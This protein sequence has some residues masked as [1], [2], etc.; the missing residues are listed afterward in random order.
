MTPRRRQLDNAFGH[1]HAKPKDAPMQGSF[2]LSK[3]D[4]PDDDVAPTQAYRRQ[5]WLWLAAITC[6]A[7]IASIITSQE[8]E[9]SGPVE[10][11][12]LP[13]LEK[14]VELVHASTEIAKATIR[15]SNLDHEREITTGLALHQLGLIIDDIENYQEMYAS[16]ISFELLPMARILNNLWEP[17]YNYSA[18]AGCANMT[19]TLSLEAYHAMSFL[20]SRAVYVYVDVRLKFVSRMDLYLSGMCSTL[21]RL[22]SK[23][24]M[25][26]TGDNPSE[27]DIQIANETA[28]NVLKNFSI[29]INMAIRGLDEICEDWGTVVDGMREVTKFLRTV[30][31][32]Y[33]NC[34][35]PATQKLQHGI[36]ELR[37]PASR[38]FLSY[39]RMHWLFEASTR[40][41]DEAMNLL[42]VGLLPS[43]RRLERAF[44]VEDE[45]YSQLCNNTTGLLA[46]WTRL[47]DLVNQFLQP[48]SK[49]AKGKPWMDRELGVHWWVTA[50]EEVHDVLEPLQMQLQ[51]AFELT[52][53]E[54]WSIFHWEKEWFKDYDERESMWKMERL[55]FRKRVNMALKKMKARWEKSWK[56][57]LQKRSENIA[58]GLR[59][60]GVLGVSPIASQKEIRLGYRNMGPSAAGNLRSHRR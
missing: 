18:P 9:K 43:F 6:L 50:P 55:P 38:A 16:S 53:R 25:P 8:N 47:S 30:I 54:Q 33:E 40:P 32:H 46:R 17:E 14:F 48:P 49:K 60:Y 26:Q 27:E 10:Y 51:R 58:P 1:N 36:Y 29:N 37:D 41:Y 20:A 12:R 39:V 11:R 31:G 22:M 35:V 21:R 34:V 5:S 52:Q 19:E 15:N 59:L 2:E 42:N 28:I 24:R 7:A 44:L 13:V 23:R 57:I 45:N 4:A 56:F 3:S